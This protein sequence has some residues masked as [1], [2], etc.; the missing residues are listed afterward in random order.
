M[1][2]VEWSVY[3]EFEVDKSLW[4]YSSSGVLHG[5]SKG[6][7]QLS[8]AAMQHHAGALGRIKRIGKETCALVTAKEESRA[9]ALNAGLSVV[10][11]IL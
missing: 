1:T 3:S 6:I 8:A 9:M 4:A 10:G 7:R 11:L 2:M 5:V